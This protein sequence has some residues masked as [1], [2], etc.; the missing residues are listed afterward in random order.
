MNEAGKFLVLAGL[1]LVLIGVLLWSGFGKGCFGRLPVDIHYS[2]G[3][4]HFYFPI[5]TCLILSA[6]L[7][8]LLWFLRK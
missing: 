4:F 1:L 8:L 2:K 3:D 7:T 6:L 5:V